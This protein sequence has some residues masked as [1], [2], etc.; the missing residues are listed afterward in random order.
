MYHAK[1]IESLST[2]D[3]LTLTGFP[4][5]RSVL[6]LSP[7]NA[8]LAKTFRTIRKHLSWSSNKNLNQITD[9]DREISQ[10]M[11][12]D[13][14]TLPQ[15][16]ITTM[17]MERTMPFGRSLGAFGNQ[18]H[19]TYAFEY[20]QE[21]FPRELSNFQDEI[22]QQSIRSQRSISA[23]Y[24][25]YQSHSHTYHS[26]WSALASLLVRELNRHVAWIDSLLHVEEDRG[27]GEP[28]DLLRCYSPHFLT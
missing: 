24:T 20:S 21:N 5:E 1:S 19:G 17:T 3:P 18:V 2:S 10:G 15:Q 11:E 8:S 27:F 22:Q 12:D 7:N 14:F 9:D 4:E 26:N 28:D 16:R 25:T 13:H 6:N 23:S